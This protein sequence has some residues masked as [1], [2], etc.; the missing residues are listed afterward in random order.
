M[1]TTVILMFALGMGSLLATATIILT[2]R[3]HWL[4]KL[5]LAVQPVTTRAVAM[6]RNRNAWVA[7][8]GL[9][10]FGGIQTGS[11][12][13]RSGGQRRLAADIVA[14]VGLAALLLFGI[15]AIKSNLVSAFQDVLASLRNYLQSNFGI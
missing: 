3:V 2:L 8:L 15:L 6:V 7:D 12:F 11:A 9:Q 4:R 14:P 1:R 10:A 5:A 13:A